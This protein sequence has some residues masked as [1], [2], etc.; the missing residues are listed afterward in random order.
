VTELPEDVVRLLRR[1]ASVDVDSDDDLDQV[2][3]EARSLL[4]RLVPEY[5]REQ[6]LERENQELRSKLSEAQQRIARYRSEVERLT[7]EVQRWT[8]QVNA[9]QARMRQ[10]RATRQVIELPG[11]TERVVAAIQNVLEL[12]GIDP[13]LVHI[14]ERPLPDDQ[15]TGEP[16]ATEV[17]S[18]AARSARASRRGGARRRPADEPGGAAAGTTEPADG[19]PGGSAPDAP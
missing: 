11:G 2:A 17:P 1:A 10:M 8:T 14:G 5:T 19:G 6:L 16:S 3:I 15:Q 18:P 9:M 4:D 12:A 7:R 13:A